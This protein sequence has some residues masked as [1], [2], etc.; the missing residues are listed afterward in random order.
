MVESGGHQS[1]ESSAEKRAECA[2]I[3]KTGDSKGQRDNGSC[4]PDQYQF[5]DAYVS[6]LGG[7][8]TRARHPGD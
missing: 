3:W 6:L 7:H 2:D 4:E 5:D 1:N 8:F